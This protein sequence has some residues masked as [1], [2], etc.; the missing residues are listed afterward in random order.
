MRYAMIMAGG[1]GTRLWPLSRQHLPKQLIEFIQVPDGT[2]GH[3]PSGCDS[4]PKSLLEL[5]AGRLEG[6]VPPERRYICTG[7]RYREVIEAQLPAFAGDRLLGEP[8][9]RDTVNAVGFAAAIFQTLDPDAVFAVLTA[10]QLIEPQSAFAESMD[11]G[12]RLVED[13]P[14]RLVTFSITPT[15]PATGYGYIQRGEPIPG[16]D[17]DQAPGQAPDSCAA[18][19]VREFKEKPDLMTATRYVAS[20]EYGWNA[21]MFIFKARTFM[22]CLERFVPESFA[23]LSKIAAAWHTPDR[24][25]VLDEVYPTLPK[26]SVDYAVME[27]A[28]KDDRV[29]ICGVEMRT[30]WLDVGSWPSYAQTLEADAD[31]NQHSGTGS[32]VS[33]QGRGNLVITGSKDHTVALLGCEDLI[34]VQTPDATLVMPKDRAE[35]LK[36]LHGLVPDGLK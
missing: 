34:V 5:S 16:S 23:G 15:H 36:D 14:S 27:P 33:T 24:K 19:A 10:D 13:D 25:R 35:S 21:G 1:A 11:R 29:S 17:P 4:K 12:F 7:E 2:P 20:G 31:H 30:S 8:A 26:I 18:F 22:E 9:P 6:V 32:L 28:S 3:D